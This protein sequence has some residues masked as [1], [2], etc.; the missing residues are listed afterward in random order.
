M[1][2]LDWDGC[3]LDANTTGEFPEQQYWY[4]AAPE[5]YQE[6]LQGIF[7]S[8]LIS[9]MARR[10]YISVGGTGYGRVDIRTRNPTSKESYILE[11]NANCGLAFGRQAS[12]LG[13]ILIIAKV[14]PSEFCKELIFY[15]INRFR[16]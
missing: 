16:S 14:E 9:D 2:K 6:Y 10:A 1:Y 5:S 3:D 11:V 12:S 13:E 15:G 4:E 8:L 7:Y